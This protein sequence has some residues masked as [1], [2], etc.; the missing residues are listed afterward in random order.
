MSKPC[1]TPANS[2]D[3]QQSGLN[4]RRVLDIY[5]EG[6]TTGI[7]EAAKTS[8]IEKAEGDAH[9]KAIVPMETLK[10]I[11]VGENPIAMLP[12]DKETVFSNQNHAPSESRGEQTIDALCP[13]QDDHAVAVIPSISSTPPNASLFGPLT[14]LAGDSFINTR[15]ARDIITGFEDKMDEQM[16][17][18]GAEMEK[19][20]TTLKEEM[21]KEIAALKEAMEKERAAFREEITALKEETTAL[22]EETIA[23]KKEMAGL[24]KRTSALEKKVFGLQKALAPAHRAAK[25]AD[26]K[27]I[28]DLQPELKLKLLSEWPYWIRNAGN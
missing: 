22:K 15:H 17:T 13:N 21:E 14:S 26:R 23:L 28:R 6:S 8:T 12:E 3:A 10:G 19:E 4:M 27:A 24:E 20:I 11:G 25:S 5:H 18:L 1:I 9:C 16:K 7:S 2:T